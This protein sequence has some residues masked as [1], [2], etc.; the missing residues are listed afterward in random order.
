[1]RRLL[2]IAHSYVVASNRRLAHEMAVQGQGRWEVTAIAPARLAAD[3][4]EVALEPIDG[5]ACTTI[6]LRVRLGRLPHLRHYER[7]LSAVLDGPWDIVHVWEEP[8]VFACAQ[9]ASAAPA[10]ACVVPATF[11][12]IR[13]RYPPP[14]ALFE[15][16]VMRRAGGWIAFGETIREVQQGKPAYASVPS[17]VIPPGVDTVRFRPDA[18][19]GAELR[20]QLGWSG[21]TPVVG[22]LGRF[23]PAK[24]LPLLMKALTHV[25]QPWRALFVGG[26]PLEPELSAFAARHPQ[27]VRIL[28]NVAH[29]EVP[30][31]LNAMDLLCAPSQTTP[32]WREQFGRMLIEAMACGV[33]VVASRSGEIPHVVEDAGVLV[34]EADGARW[35]A[36]IERLLADPDA[37]ASLSARG[38]LR[39]QER[40][41]WPV[42]ARAHLA[43]F[44]ELITTT[45]E[46]G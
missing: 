1:M 27:R 5:E 29:D 21:E 15:R 37:R 22:F 46:T 41:S 31:H 40:F 34:D 7:R 4:R 16:R 42:V 17:R 43:F 44:D 24:G 10:G 20:A 26:G 18:S 13:K 39:A 45:R 2:S 9:V 3:L 12:N 14:L 28:T 8:Y 36:E 38:L 23:V 35:T 33:P 11:Q 19:A 32:A 30:R 6:A 25:K